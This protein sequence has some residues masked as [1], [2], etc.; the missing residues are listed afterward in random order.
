MTV[1]NTCH[2]HLKLVITIFIL[3][4]TWVTV[5]DLFKLYVAKLYSL[6]SEITHFGQHYTHQKSISDQERTRRSQ[7]SNN[8]FEELPKDVIEGLYR[9]YWLDFILYGYDIPSWIA[10]KLSWN[11]RISCLLVIELWKGRNSNLISKSSS[12][13]NRFAWSTANTFLWKGNWNESW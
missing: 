11:W 13:D 5:I 10:D 6:I 7:Q 3:S 1:L 12:N 4:P 2:P 8:L 9:H